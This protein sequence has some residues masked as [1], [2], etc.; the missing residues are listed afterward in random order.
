MTTVC[1][2]SDRFHRTRAIDYLRGSRDLAPRNNVLGA[3]I[4]IL[5]GPKECAEPN[6]LRR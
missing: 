2:T 3:E 4:C 1:P 5:E 6:G